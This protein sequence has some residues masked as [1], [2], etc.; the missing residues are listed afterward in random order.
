MGARTM[1]VSRILVTL[2]GA[3]SIGI[4]ALHAE[5]APVSKPGLQARAETQAK[6]APIDRALIDQFCVTCHNEKLKTGGLSL[7]SLDLTQVSAN[8]DVLEKIVRKLGTGQMP[9]AGRPRPESKVAEA[10]V[11]S[12]EAALDRAAS[13]A[14][15]PGRVVV[16][17]LNRLEYV[18]SIHD[19][20]ALDIDATALLPAD[21]GGVGFDNNADVLSVTPALMNRYLSAATKISRLAIGDPTIRPAIQVYRASEW[22]TQTTRANE[23]QPFGT[24]GGLAVRHAFPLDGEY[25]IKVRL[26]R[27]FF[28]GTIFG[29]DDEHEIEIRLDGGVVQRYKVGGKYKGADA[30]ILIA[31]P[32]DEPDMQ[33]LHAY[34]LDADQDFNFRI[35]VK[36]GARLITAAFSD[37]APA[38]WEMV[39]LRPRSLK[40]SN[41]DDARDPGIDSIEISGPYD[42]RVPDDTASRR[43]IFACRPASVQDEDPCARKILSTLAR[44]AYRRPVTDVDVRELM[45]LY[46]LGRQEGGFDAGVG[47]ALEGLLA[48]PAFLFRVEHDP[49]DARPGAV[50]RVSD[51]ELASRVS[52]FLW[53]SVP[54]DELLDVAARGRLRE[55]A[56]LAQQVRRMMSDARASRFLSDFVG[57]WLTIRNLQAQEPDPV[58]FPE[59]SDNLRAAMLRETELFFES[60]V[61]ENRNVLDLLRADYTYLNE[62]LARHYNVPSVY[63]DHFRRVPVSNPARQGLL[64][65]ASILT[66]TSYAHRTSVVLRGKWVLENILGTPP[67]P[68][69]PNV[70]PLKENDGRSAPT[71]LKER[72]ENHRRNPVCA[73]CHARIDPNG[74]ALENF[75]ATGK[76]RTSDE[77]APIEA[78]S[79][80]ADGTKVDGVTSFRA[81]LLARGDQ[82]V[83]TVTEKLF[84]YAMGRSLD[85]Y[86]APTVRQLVREVA[87]E[88][89]RWSAL[90]LGIVGSQPF[91]SRRVQEPKA[92][93]AV[94]AQAR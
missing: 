8:A 73:S 86:D 55:P 76:W 21:N 85:Y 50:Y 61:R 43:L 46:G 92:A 29:I 31:I 2:A 57:Q 59:F 72:M 7:Q 53:K 5:Q 65:H 9:P 26:Q 82:F 13:A 67:P 51:L 64:G 15:N 91:Q 12:L 70:P 81:V 94:V 58:K 80:L 54:D 37:R 77:G 63:G 52:F 22:G 6:P 47:R 34:H 36:G 30:G 38:V 25:R 93:P 71:S 32:E 83:R 16:H 27:N 90:I 88:D 84:A 56:V 74:F 42:A 45:R 14:P 3:A 33:K 17:R 62:T 68:P 44:R 78:A 89:N 60:Q 66:V 23:D 35:F 28:G 18:N 10:F 24:H 48:M 75:D 41:F 40:N 39:P 20:L 49:A 4:A 87:R 11:V 69:P 79:A 19:L 1:P